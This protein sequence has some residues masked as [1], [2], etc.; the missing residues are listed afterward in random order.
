[1]AAPR[2]L[3]GLAVVGAALAAQSP[4][5]RVTYTRT[6]PNSDPVYLK[7]AVARDGAA[8]YAARETAAEPVLSLRYQASPQAVRVIFADAAALD[9][10]RRPKLQSKDNVAFTGSKT[11]AYDGSGIHAAQDFTFTTVSTARALEA[12]FEKISATAM[13]ALR[14]QRAVTYQPLDVLGILDQIRADW[15]MHQLAEP[16]IL[17]PVLRRLAADPSQMQASRHR[18]RNLLAA[19]HLRAGTG[20]GR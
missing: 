18:A 14:L 19:M 11:L 20:A 4:A 8:V 12:L 17:A 3:L 5:A 1:M 13:Y 2:L 6:F 7:I 10:F 9:D 16:Q 15:A